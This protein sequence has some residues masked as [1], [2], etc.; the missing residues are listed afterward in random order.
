[1]KRAINTYIARLLRN[2][3]NSLSIINGQRHG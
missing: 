1:M 2:G 3:K